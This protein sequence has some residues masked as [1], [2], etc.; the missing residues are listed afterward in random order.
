MLASLA[1]GTENVEE[2]FGKEMANRLRSIKAKYDP[3]NVWTKGYIF[4]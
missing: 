2:I 4:R 1:Y 3:D